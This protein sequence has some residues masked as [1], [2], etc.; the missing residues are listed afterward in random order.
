MIIFQRVEDIT[1]PN[2]VHDAF[3]QFSASL[4]TQAYETQAAASHRTSIESRLQASFGMSAFFRTGS[5]GNGTNVTGYSDVDYF[6]VIPTENLKGDSG[7]TLAALANDLR[8]RFPTTSG[9]RVDN[10]GVIIPF[11]LDGAEATEI[12]PVDLTGQTHLGFRQFDMPDGSGGWKFSAPESHKAYMKS[13]DDDL[14][15]NARRLVRIVKAW[16]YFRGVQIKSFYL[17]MFVARYCKTE[18]IILF[19]HDVRTVLRLLVEGG[20]APIIDPRFPN[21]GVFL[22]PC[23]TELQRSDS[24]ASAVRASGWA[25]EAVEA[26]SNSKVGRAFERWDLVF[27]GNFPAFTS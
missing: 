11:G 26:N 8:L 27:N 14:G 23:N 22:H 25:E 4:R 20:L 15:G 12:V 13:L 10:P 9:I 6:A 24:L 1:L 5:F 2:T 21:D 19:E 17:E 3:T 16:K 7:A 18:S